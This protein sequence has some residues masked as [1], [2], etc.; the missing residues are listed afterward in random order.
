MTGWRMNRKHE[1][2]E[3]NLEIKIRELKIKK[4]KH[5]ITTASRKPASKE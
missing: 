3:R 2:A 4:G 5:G 1:L